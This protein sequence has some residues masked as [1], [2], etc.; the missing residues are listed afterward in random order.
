[1]RLFLLVLALL[2][3]PP[4][5]GCTVGGTSSSGTQLVA[6]FESEAPR[7]PQALNGLIDR[8]AGLYRIPA[9]LIHRVVRRESGYNPRA[10]N[11]PYWGLMQ[12]RVDT[13]RSMG[14]YGKPADLLDA[15]TNL[16]YAA[17]YLAGAYVVANGNADRAVSF[18][19]RGYYYDAKRKGLLE[20]TG[21]RPKR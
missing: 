21:L 5:A 12:I 18:Y 7:G 8:Y 4:L 9:S 2:A 13:A 3:L 11:G 20:E 15:D 19:A 16:R 1:M 17:K 6:R 14:F 10:R